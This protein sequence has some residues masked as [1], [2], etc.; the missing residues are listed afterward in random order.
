MKFEDNNTDWIWSIGN[1][2]NDMQVLLT[3]TRN[4]FLTPTH[5]GM[6]VN[7]NVSGGRTSAAFLHWKQS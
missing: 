3:E 5:I 2:P 7:N 6:V 1:D 4:T